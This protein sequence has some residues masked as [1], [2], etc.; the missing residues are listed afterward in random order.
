MLSKGLYA[1][2]VDND[3]AITLAEYSKAILT[4]AQKVIDAAVLDTFKANAAGQSG[5][6]NYE[7]TLAN[8]G[9][10]L[11]PFHDFDSQ[12]SADLKAGIDALKQKIIS[13]DVKVSDYLK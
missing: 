8:G 12:I 13:G 11:S 6:A 5:G 4:S 7:G 1:I 10:A 9:V 2:G 3:Q